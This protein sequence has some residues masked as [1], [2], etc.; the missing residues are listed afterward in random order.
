V[1]DEQGTAVDP[2]KVVTAEA[3]SSALGEPVGPARQLFEQPLPV[4]RMRGCQYVATGDRHASVSVFTAGG[5]VMKLLMR[6]NE[7]MGDAVPGVGD[8]AY[9][10]ADSLALLRGEVV[11]SIRLQSR[12]V[13]DRS[14]ALRQL[15]VAADRRLTTATEAPA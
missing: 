7:R 3:A 2:A 12:R 5:E 4:G 6:V 8:R 14:A 9:L 11:V 15:A 1:L 10:R 13:P